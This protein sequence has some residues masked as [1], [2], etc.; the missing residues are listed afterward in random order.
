MDKYYHF[1]SYDNL[2]SISENGL[3]PQRG[4]RTITIGDEK[5]AV[6]L[7]KGMDN[8]IRM[9]SKILWY[10]SQVGGDEG[11]RIISS[12]KKRIKEC[13]EEIQ[14]NSVFSDKYSKEVEDMNNY[15]ETIKPLSRIK[16]FDDY[17]GDGCYLSVN[18]IDGVLTRICTY[19]D[20]YYEKIILPQ[21]IN[22]VTIRN[23]NTNEVI[24]QREMVLTYFMSNYDPYDL[25]ADEHDVI[26]I[27]TIID[28][29]NDRM[30]A[31]NGIYNQNNYD[32]EE[33]PIKKYVK[34]L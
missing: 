5:N 21:E 26:A 18:G 30:A 27:K 9:Y 11:K 32:I 1:T 2:E 4:F 22:V 6:F 13:L 15:I 25:L 23:H 17:L 3:I 33:I 31:I 24:D 16:T 8:A 7:S 14:N 12:Y 28:L 29:Y 10:Y 34:T 20:C 19:D